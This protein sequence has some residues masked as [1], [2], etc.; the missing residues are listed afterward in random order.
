MIFKFVKKVTKILSL[1]AIVRLSARISADL[2][3]YGV[4]H[5]KDPRIVIGVTAA[6]KT[7]DVVAKKFKRTKFDSTSIFDDS[8]DAVIDAF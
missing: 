8:M 2:V 3:F 1:E 4:T 5:F 6:V 7:S